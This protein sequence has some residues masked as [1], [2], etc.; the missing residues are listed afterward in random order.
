[1]TGLDRYNEWYI[2]KVER[3]QFLSTVT[4]VISLLDFFLTGGCGLEACFLH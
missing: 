2:I 3:L 1:M 4:P